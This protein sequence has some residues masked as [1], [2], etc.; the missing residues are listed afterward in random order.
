MRFKGLLGVVIII[1]VASAIFLA[2]QTQPKHS[3][4]E[5]LSDYQVD[6]LLRAEA[7]EASAQMM[8]GEWLLDGSFGIKDEFR[9]R[10][11]FRLAA[12]QGHADAQFELADLIVAAF[13][14][15]PDDASD[16]V[17]AESNRWLRLAADQGHVE[18][19]K[20]LAYRYWQ[21]EGLE[22]NDAEAVRWMEQAAR[23]GDSL[24]QSF[25][26]DAY[27][28]GV[29]VPPD[30]GKAAAWNL[31]AAQSGLQS[32]QLELGI[33]LREGNGVPQD[34]AQAVH[35]LTLAAEGD[36][37]LAEAK[38]ELARLYLHGDRLVQDKDRAVSL[39]LEIGDVSPEAQYELAMAYI[40]GE[41]V[42]PK[43]D[44]RLDPEL[45]K[46]AIELALDP[47]AASGPKEGADVGRDLLVVSAE[48]GFGQAQLELGLMIMSG[49]G[50]AADPA[51]AVRWLRAAADQGL[52]DAQYALGYAYGT[53][54]GVAKDEKEAYRL[55][56][57]AAEQGHAKAQNAVAWHAYNGKGTVQDV[58]VAVTWYRRAAL[59][60]DPVAQ[61][62][63]GRHYA[64]GEGVPQ[65]NLKAHMWTN[66]ALSNGYDV[67]ADLREK[68]NDLSNSLSPEDLAAAQAMASACVTS[69]YASCGEPGQVE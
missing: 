5:T 6:V 8:M 7:G 10:E 22:K 37:G 23:K 11:W 48:A 66:I 19:S 26:A 29:G 49:E 46:D 30:P 18:A 62:Y 54:E 14:Y 21:G 64:L 1:A 32:A 69:G 33:A 41:A 50:W 65:N 61:R 20:A 55:M 25:L 36:Y 42:P 9:A 24:A 15:T 12:E 60:G 17:L 67:E 40:S 53:G 63:L 3:L 47:R 51:V 38:L 13:P 68:L 28:D 43:A 58:A 16:D 59:Q 35:W 31:K 34:A 45:H 57:A 2:P 44:W 27:A 56:L 52:A 39:Y 4:S